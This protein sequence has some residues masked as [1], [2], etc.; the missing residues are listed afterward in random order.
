MKTTLANITQANVPEKNVFVKIQVLPEQQETIED[1]TS[2]CSLG[3]HVIDLT[4]LESA[5]EVSSA[6]SKTLQVL[7]S[8]TGARFTATVEGLT[9]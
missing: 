2:L 4:F 6:M 7:N 1:C 9:Y 8:E 5:W 3:I